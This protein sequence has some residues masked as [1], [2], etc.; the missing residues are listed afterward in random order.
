MR[1]A[2]AALGSWRLSLNADQVSAN[3]M[4]SRSDYSIVIA[5]SGTASRAYGK[6]MSAST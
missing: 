5:S 2:R 3:S 6:G 4:S 1:A